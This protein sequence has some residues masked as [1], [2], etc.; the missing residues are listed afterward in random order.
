[1]ATTDYRSIHAFSLAD[2]DAFWS[3]A[4]DLIDWARKPSVI[5]DSRNAPM[6]KWYTDGRLNTCY[7][8][9]DR[10]VDGG[11]GDRA[12]IIYESPVT[13]MSR[14]LSY[15]ELLAEVALFAG[16]LQGQ[17]VEKGDRVLIYMP[18][19]PEGL[20]AMLACARIGAVHCT[21][22]GGF[23]SSELATRID[24]CTPRVIVAASCGIEPKGVIRYMPMVDAALDQAH[25]VPS[26]V[27]VLQREQCVASLK[28]GRDVDWRLAVSE[29][30]PAA[31][32][33]LDATDPLYILY[34]SGTTGQPKG[35]VRDNGGHA[36]ALAWSMANLFDMHAGETFWAASDIGWQV[37]H[38]YTLYGPLLAGCTSILYEGKPVGTPDAAAFWR[39]IERHKVAILLT[40]PTAIRAIRRED[41]EGKLIENHDLTSLRALFLAGERSDPDT[42]H[43]VETKLSTTVVDHWWQTESGWPITG[44][45]LGLESFP[46]RYGSV[47]VPMVGWN[48]A[49][50]R[51]DG[52][53]ADVGEQ[54]S[55]VV[56]LPLPPGALT[57]LWNADERFK[58]V[59]LSEF[60]GYYCSGDAGYIDE[61]GY[62]WVMARTDDVINVAGHRMATGALEEIVCAHP[63][64]AECAVIGAADQL[65]GQ[66]PIGLL[67]LNDGATKLPEDIVTDVVAMVTAHVGAVACF[68]KAAV[69]DR[70]PKTRSG[71]ILRSTIQKMADGEDVKAPATID[72]PSILP[73][74]EVALQTIGYARRALVVEEQ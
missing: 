55:I 22:F 52:E 32:V 51:P 47:T 21:V 16:V 53:R 12:A 63:D 18:M 17:G 34:T 29:A 30:T 11:A 64:V 31:C 42:L 57:T 38:T 46:I 4:A 7:N 39:V 62:V 6:T 66:V 65:K 15:S 70:L 41:P 67:V 68:R 27:I 8:A 19:V 71:K 73:E 3:Q 44:N 14:T 37:G 43:W 28:D 72:D 36:V 5:F 48:V 74:I 26:A 25:H 54:G 23:A 20:V 10:H 24:D 35:V 9:L 13:G 56:E 2:R 60:P 49:V 69:V 50:L 59:Y 33:D 45:P 61:D 40:A 58:S 1:M